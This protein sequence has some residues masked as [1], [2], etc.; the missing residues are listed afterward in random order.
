MPDTLRVGI[1][2]AGFIGRVH[3]NCWTALP[4]AEIVAAADIRPEVIKDMPGSP[5]P[6]S[7]HREMLDKAELDIVDVCIP[8]PWHAE[9]AIDALN[10]GA[11]VLCEKPMA[12]T[13]EEC[14]AMIRAGEQSGKAFMVAH[15]IRFW[16]EYARLKQ[17]ADSGEFG[18]LRSFTCRR[19]MAMPM[20][21]WDLWPHDE[22]RGGGIP[23]EGH[24]HDVDYVR[25]LLGDPKAVSS[26]AVRDHTGIGQMWSNYYY[27]N[28]VA[29]Q[30]EGSWGYTQKYP[31]QHG[32][33]AVFEGATVDYDLGREKTLL[34]Y[35]PDAEPEEIDVSVQEVG[36]ADAG[37]NISDLGGYYR[38]IE[39]FAGC[40]HR[41]EQ[42]S[43]TTPRDARESVRL[44]LAQI[45]SS[46]TRAVV[47]LS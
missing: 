32:Y 31:F 2:G 16:P 24:I 1:V 14:D 44:V 12:F 10:A 9:T 30:A 6:F 26:V 7:S 43:V 8:T 35:K 5:Q 38:E 34:L 19:R 15:V 39:Y 4:G 23:F 42:P 40:V 18:A 37:G 27:D 28:N 3:A 13:L 25:Y 20:Y 41:G 29:G 46:K 11:N 22:K 33:I 17:I 36:S 45:E 21:N 47:P